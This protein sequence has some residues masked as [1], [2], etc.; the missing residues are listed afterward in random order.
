MLEVCDKS[1]N[2][3]NSRYAL[4]RFKAASID[5]SS[6]F[7]RRG[8]LIANT[9]VIIVRSSAFTVEFHESNE[10]EVWLNAPILCLLLRIAVCKPD[11]FSQNPSKI[12]PWFGEACKDFCANWQVNPSEV[13][14]VSQ[15]DFNFLIDKSN[16][17]FAIFPFVLPG[18]TPV[19]VAMPSHKTRLPAWSPISRVSRGSSNVQNPQP[20]INDLVG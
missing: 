10:Y 15:T 16:G 11:S 18:R 1:A 6:N 17:N 2:F 13:I 8:L 5:T 19:L 12:N 7:G 14:C 9:E 20:F 3:I 4:Y